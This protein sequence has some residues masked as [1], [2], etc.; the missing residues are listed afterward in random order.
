MAEGVKVAGSLFRGVVPHGA[1][2][3]GRPAP[4]ICGSKWA[5][6]FKVGKPTPVT[7]RLGG[8]PR[9]MS[10]DLA[11]RWPAA[12]VD[13]VA[14]YQALVDAMELH[15]Q[16]R[17]ELAGRDLACWCKIGDPCHRDVLLAVA[18]V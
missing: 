17:V 11:G 16:V 6:P 4:G 2:Y 9:T 14:W 10:T 1:V 15:A 12:T 8:H 13:A 3:V 7:V 18:N 5:N